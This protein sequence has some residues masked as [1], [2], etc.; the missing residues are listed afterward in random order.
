[1]TKLNFEEDTFKEFSDSFEEN[2]Y[3]VSEYWDDYVNLIIGEINKNK[4]QDFGTNRDL[5]KGFGDALNIQKRPKLRKLLAFKF[6]YEPVE[7]FLTTKKQFKNQKE[8]FKSAF[9][10]FSKHDFINKIAND[11]D[12]TA[13]ELG[14]NR[15][16]EINNKKVPWRYLQALAYIELLDTMFVKH[17]KDLCLID[18]LD[19]NT[20]DIGG[21]YGPMIDTINE[22]KNHNNIGKGST[23]YLLEQYPVSFIANQYLKHR[24]GR[25]KSPILRKDFKDTINNNL[26]ELRVIQSGFVKHIDNLDIKFYF[27]SN[28]FQEM[29]KSQVLEYC[30]F[31]KRNKAEES[32]LGIFHY[33]DSVE[34]NKIDQLWLVNNKHGYIE[35][36]KD[37]FNL[38]EDFNFELHGFVSGTIYLFKL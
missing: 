1:M 37:E 15:F 33:E 3:K 34:V 38:I 19:G 12:I 10:F 32:F 14:I 35:M 24:H 2:S 26:S 6:L 4:L 9:N 13:S 17:S 27:N 36:F 22:F 8:V 25:I 23:D 28:S 31:I 30:E 18:I 7:K 20:I 16:N 21:G 5:T 11:L 29:N